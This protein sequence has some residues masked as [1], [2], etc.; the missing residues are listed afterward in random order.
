MAVLPISRYRALNLN[1]LVLMPK[2]G[3]RLEI[4]HTSCFFFL[5]IFSVSID[6]KPC[7]NLDIDR[8]LFSG[9]SS[10]FGR[11]PVDVFWQRLHSK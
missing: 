8:S 3:V 4:M 10:R 11:T 7:F 9:D 5:F 6:V 2:V 1:S